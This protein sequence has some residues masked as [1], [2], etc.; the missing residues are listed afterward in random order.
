MSE[1]DLQATTWLV[2]AASFAIA[3][4]FGALAQQTRFC[5][6]GAVADVAVMGD[7]TRL[8]LWGIAMGTAIVGFQAMV[9]LGWVAAADSFYAGPNLLWLSAA[10]GGA[11]FGV[12]MVLAG[13]CASRNLLRAGTGNLKALVVLLVVAFAGF[14]TLKGITAVWRV[15]TVDAVYVAL[16]GSQD[17]PSILARATG[18]P[19]ARWAG[20]LGLALGGALLAACAWPRRERA[21]GL[22]LGGAGLGLLVVAAWWV[23]G[24]LGHVTEHPVTLEPAFLA[25]NSR[26]MEALS[27]V[28]AVSHAADY[29]LFFSDAAKVL[30]IGVVSAAGM[31]LG[32]AL[33]ALATRSLRW[34][35]FTNI[36]DLRDHLAGGVL[37]GVGGVTALGCTI[38]QG[39]SGISTLSVSSFIALA[40]I[41]G[42][43]VAALK[44]QAWRIER[45]AG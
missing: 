36:A 38:G 18:S 1:T 15:H 37:M 32:A 39:L 2:L 10:L 16:A 14:A 31:I 21:P 7:W 20:T 24:V 25:T 41:V 45:A 30:T 23:S 12:G 29:L 17:L 19:A 26:R 8:R 33:H 34:E 44:L 27:F 40:G 5:T 9:A 28:A 43:A 22:I 35:G 42:G 6:M 11:A 13:G 3:V 4:A